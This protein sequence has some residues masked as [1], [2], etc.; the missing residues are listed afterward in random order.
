MI[1]GV[2]VILFED[3]T[4]EEIY[5]IFDDMLYQFDDFEDDIPFDRYE[6]SSILGW[7]AKHNRKTLGRCTYDGGRYRISLNPNMLKFG[8]DG[9][10]IIKNTIAHELCHTLPGCM[11]HGPEFHK[12]AKL[13]GDLMG[14]KIDTKAD[15]DASGYFRQYLP[16]ANY[17]LKC[18]SCGNEIPKS[19]I[20]D[21][22]TN[23]S[24][25]TCGRCK[26]TLDSYKLNKQTGEYEVYK[27][28][29]DKPEYKYKLICP[30]C[31]WE[32]SF[33]TRNSK[34]AKYVKSLRYGDELGCPKCGKLNLYA[35]DNGK[36][37]S[38][39]TDVHYY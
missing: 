37:V 39:N 23:P 27:T 33:K 10:Q 21:A 9:H 20:C 36:K 8:E 15:V 12:Y 31:G 29:E 4:E 2:Y 1:W 17:M 26:G 35:L 19:G 5:D 34:F 3:Y 24:R 32:W 22:V 7:L 13:I 30:D 28:H 16:Q 11:N 6:V 18:N 25:Y 14:Y 38:L